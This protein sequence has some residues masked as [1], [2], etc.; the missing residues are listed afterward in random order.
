M[1]LRLRKNRNAETQL[2]QWLKTLYVINTIK[3]NRWK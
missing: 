3:C 1:A 2:Q